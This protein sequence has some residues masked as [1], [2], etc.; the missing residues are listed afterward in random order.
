M[1]GEERF[2]QETERERGR[3]G[4]RGLGQGGSSE[5]ESQREADR[6]KW[7]ERGRDRRKAR[8]RKKNHWGRDISICFGNI[9]VHITVFIYISWEMY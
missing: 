9:T 4:K 3:K 2:D 6:G 8:F 7:G 1:I 5:R